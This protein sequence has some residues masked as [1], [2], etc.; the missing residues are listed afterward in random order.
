MDGGSDSAVNI[1]SRGEGGMDPDLSSR[2]ESCIIETASGVSLDARV[3]R[4]KGSEVAVVLVHPYSVLGGFQGLMKG[5]AMGLA[6]RGFTSLTFNMRGV[7]NSTGRSSLTGS[8]EVEDVVAV[9]QW[10]SRHLPTSRILL[11]GSSAGAAIAGSAVDEVEEVVGYV[12]IGYPFGW[13]ASILLGR[14]QK[15][16]LQSR[17]PKLFVMGTRDG[18]TSVS[19]LHNKLLDTWNSQTHLV[20]G[21]SHFQMEGPAFDAQMVDLISQ[22]IHNH[23]ITTPTCA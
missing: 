8:S 12:G 22:F 7:G 14:H 21:V 15:G 23:F 13:T 17:K 11:V 16:I 19:Q 10:A 20:D 1:Q 2:R 18:F 5:I 6:A 3:Y 9:C 4:G